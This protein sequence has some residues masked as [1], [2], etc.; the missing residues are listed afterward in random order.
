MK[1]VLI[2]GGGFAG[3]DAASHLRKL[4]YDVTL[5][6]DRDYFY[7]YPTSIWIPTHES[8]FEDVCVDLK[9]LQAAHGFELIVDA[10]SEISKAEN[11]VKLAS[12]KILNDYDYL[13]I[14]M[15]ASKMKPKGVEHALSICG[16]PELSLQRRDAVDR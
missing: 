3:V 7:I 5:V 16:A 12:G 10:V 2:L 8:S 4:N 15:G 14:A 6:S 11:F 9:E 1:K 13:N